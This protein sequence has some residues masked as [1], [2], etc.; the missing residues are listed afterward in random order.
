MVD[1]LILK[2]QL[3]LGIAT[4]MARKGATA[5]SIGAILGIDLPTGPGATFAGDLTVI[6]MGP[7]SWLAVKENAAPGF[8]DQLADALAGLAS[9]SDQ[10]SGYAAWEIAGPEAR[11]LLQRGAFI[12]FHDDVF[13]T[14]SAVTTVIAHIGVIIWQVDDRPGYYA[15]TFRSYASSFLHWLDQV[16]KAL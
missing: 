15:A 1:T 13:K 8:V 14:G 6:G 3:D 7:E 16:A 10:S 4:I 5:A 2:E 9:V 11:T 12:D